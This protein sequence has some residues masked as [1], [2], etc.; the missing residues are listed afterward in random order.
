[1]EVDHGNCECPACLT[2]MTALGQVW[3][4]AVCILPP[5]S[6]EV[7]S[8]SHAPSFSSLSSTNHIYMYVC[9]GF[10]VGVG[11]HM[12]MHLR[13]AWLRACPDPLTLK[14]QIEGFQEGEIQWPGDK[15]LTEVLDPN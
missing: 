1:M 9:R 7:V 8:R 5:H 11:V 14:A 13:Y 12:C 6:V 10:W 2:L 4:P 15:P 3:G